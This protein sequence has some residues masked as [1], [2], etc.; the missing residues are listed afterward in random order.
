[1]VMPLRPPKYAPMVISTSVKAVNKNVVRRTLIRF[2]C[3]YIR[4]PVCRSRSGG[5]LLFRLRAFE[6]HGVAFAIA[7]HTNVFARE[8][9]AFKNLQDQS[10]LHQPLNRATQRPGTVGWVITFAR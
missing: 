3:N 8:R 4:K 9:L 5:G 7:G 2:P 1:M 10:I 6:A